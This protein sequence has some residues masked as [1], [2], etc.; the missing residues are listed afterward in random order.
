MLI[1]SYT[2]KIRPNSSASISLVIIVDF[3]QVLGL[4][5]CDKFVVISVWYDNEMGYL[6]RLRYFRS[7]GESGLRYRH[8]A[9]M[10]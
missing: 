4:A 8:I 7:H 1:L 10:K 3:N 6:R 9:D 2:S 5:I